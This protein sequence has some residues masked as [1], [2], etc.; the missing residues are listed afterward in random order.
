MRGRHV[1]RKVLA[2]DVPM[3]LGRALADH[4]ANQVIKISLAFLLL[5]AVACAGGWYLRDWLNITTATP[6][7]LNED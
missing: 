1:L 2:R 6:D 4:Y 3:S 7:D 5:N